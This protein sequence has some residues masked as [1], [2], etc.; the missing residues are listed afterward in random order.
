MRPERFF[1]FHVHS[2][3]SGDSRVPL[4]ERAR[5]A[6]GEHPHGISDHFPSTQLRTL[7]DVARYVERARTLGLR[8]ALEYD[9]GIAE[10][11]PRSIRTSLDYLVGGLHQVVV[12]GVAVSYDDA[13]SYL[14]GRVTQFA[15]R[16]R[17]VDGSDFG[18][19][20][21]EEILRTLSTSFEDERFDILAHPTFS[22]LAAVG[23]ADVSYPAEWQE[24][25]IALCVRYGTALEVNESYRLPH[26]RFL[27]RA[28]DAG[29]TFSVGSDSHEELLPLSY[30][31]A[32]IGEAGIAARVR[33]PREP[34]RQRS[35][36]SGSARSS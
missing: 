16:A 1:D 20:V 21:M 11:L 30:A 12:D 9:I 6:A 26:A 17:Y 8:V 36:G 2:A 19:A 29:A 3:V 13:G 34:A 28:R 24:R 25:L 18:R 15:D 14:K 33:D 4:E 32:V 22:P 10:P 35:V 31:Q 7:D 5:T 23:D 27:R